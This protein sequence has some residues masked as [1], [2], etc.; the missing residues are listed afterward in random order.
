[1]ES[2][3]SKLT[4]FF[5]DPFWVGVYERRCDHCCTVCKITFGR[6]PKDGEVYDIL[7]KHWRELRFSPSVEAA[8]SAE[9][10]KNPKRR[11][12][13]IRRQLTN[14]GVGTKAQQALQLQREQNKNVRKQTARTKKETE[15]NYRFTLRQ[16]KRKEKHRGH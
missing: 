5:E 9:T 7:L 15:Q 10:I 16:Q 4:V 13:C 11:Q 3:V 1:M 14:T 8:C 12:R 2:T 6:E